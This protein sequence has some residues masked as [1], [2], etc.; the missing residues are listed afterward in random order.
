MIQWT[1][2]NLRE[3]VTF[4]GKSP[5]FDEYF[6]SW[7]EFEQYVHAHS[8]IFKL[9]CEDG[10]H[11]E[12]P[13]GA[14]IVKT[15]DGYN[16]PSVARFV[17]AKQEQPALPGIEKPG[18]P[19]RDFIPVE[20]VDA[21]E[22]YG[23]WKIVKQEQSEVDIEKKITEHAEN[24]PHGEFTHDS[25]CVEHEEWA[26]REFRYFYEVGLNTRKK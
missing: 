22:R 11:Y 14:W 19:G 13:V 25:E 18:I 21:C 10:S 16:V 26:K 3:V 7:E 1:G 23:K 24:M 6:K 4:T 9:F 8:D 12:V 15:P 20:W 5:K 2:Q 17:Y